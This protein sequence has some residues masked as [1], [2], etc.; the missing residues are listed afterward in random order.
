MKNDL[1]RVIFLTLFLSNLSDNRK[2]FNHPSNRIQDQPVLIWKY[3]IRDNSE[4][5]RY[6]TKLSIRYD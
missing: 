6:P 1:C 5:D 2:V 3:T 4:K